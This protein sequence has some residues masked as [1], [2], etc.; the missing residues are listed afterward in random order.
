MRP[1]PNRTMKLIDEFRPE[2]FSQI[3]G[4]K[5][6]IARIERAIQMN[7]GSANGLVFLLTGATGNGK[8]LIA[9]M[10]ADV[11]DGDVYRPDCTEDSRTADVINLVK[12]HART[13]AWYTGTSV[14]IFDEAD[15]LSPNNIAKLKI[16]V[17]YIDTCRREGKLCPVVLIFTT[18]KTKEQLTKIYCP[19]G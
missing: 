1:T 15:R 7:D 16:T 6:A 12:T 9:D 18:A 10:L 17:D 11:I 13:G 14:F 19:G 5:Q 4:N 8:T 2:D 3:V